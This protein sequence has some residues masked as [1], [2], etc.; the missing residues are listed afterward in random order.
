MNP[1]KKRKIRHH[2]TVKPFPINEVAF[3][4]FTGLD[5]EIFDQ[6]SIKL[7]TNS[8]SYG[9]TSRPRQTIAKS[10]D[11][12]PIIL[13]PEEAFFLHNHIKCLMVRDIDDKIISADDLWKKYCG[14]KENFVDCY[15]A[16]LYF[17]SKNWVVK[18]G[19]KFGGNF[20]MTNS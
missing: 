8:G 7:L 18:V 17:K 20:C 3:G 10:F 1:V 2:Y 5:V 6:K 16:Y 9:F 14:I 13:F 19:T 12:Q 4:L 11:K 15:V